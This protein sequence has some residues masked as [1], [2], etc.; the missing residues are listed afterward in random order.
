M[1]IEENKA[2]VRRFFTRFTGPDVYLA[3]C[4]ELID[5]DFVA[6]WQDGSEWR[7]L[8]AVRQIWRGFFTAFPEFEW[9][10]E[11]MVAEGDKVAVRYSGRGVQQGEFL[12]VTV[13]NRPMVVNGHLIYRLAGGKLV[14][15][16]IQAAWAV[17]TGD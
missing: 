5:A 15:A 10:I 7:G 17:D 12:G 6:H 1:S 9:A 3:L 2:I 8:D 11:D 16:W 13:K 14:E 4:D